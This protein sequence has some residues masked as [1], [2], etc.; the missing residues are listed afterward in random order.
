[1]AM[2]AAGL[3]RQLARC[4][5][6]AVPDFCG[7]NG[8]HSKV[9]MAYNHLWD[10]IEANTAHLGTEVWSWQ[11][12][13]GAFRFLDFGKLSPTG[14]FHPKFQIVRLALPEAANY[15]HR[16]RY[17]PSLVANIFICETEPQSS[18]TR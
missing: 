2:M 8:L 4:N 11:Y 16:S 17:R 18:L 10:L 12:E 5:S 15:L 13:N 14:E 3:E 6:N 1:M 7:D 9:L